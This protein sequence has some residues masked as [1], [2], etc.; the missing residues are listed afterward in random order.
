MYILRKAVDT[1]VGGP[2]GHYDASFLKR[3]KL[4]SLILTGPD[5]KKRNNG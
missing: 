4:F 3:G 5:C 1:L 2:V